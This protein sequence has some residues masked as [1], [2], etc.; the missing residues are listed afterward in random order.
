MQRSH[1][2]FEDF[3]KENGLNL[4]AQRKENSKRPRDGC[5]SYLQ[6]YWRK[7]IETTFSRITGMFP[8]F[9]HA[10]TS[11]GF[12]LKIFAFILVYSLKLM[13]Q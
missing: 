7:R 8:K 9:I 10:I 13:L 6:N 5:L 1:Y 3:L 2:E 11:R 12:E 4:I